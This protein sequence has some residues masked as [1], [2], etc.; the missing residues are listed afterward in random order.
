MPT[1]FHSNRPGL[2]G[3]QISL[4][5]G[6]HVFRDMQMSSL[7]VV[8]LWTKTLHVNFQVNPTSGCTVKAILYF[9]PVIAP[10]GGQTPLFL[11]KKIC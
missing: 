8:A 7:T 1:E 3:A 5:D 9:C 4:G 10:H 2:I 6:S 11:I